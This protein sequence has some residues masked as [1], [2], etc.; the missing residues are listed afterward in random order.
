LYY[1]E[2][3]DGSATYKRQAL[4]ACKVQRLT[5]EASEEN[6]VARFSMSGIGST[7]EPNDQFGFDG[8]T[9]TA[10]DATEFPEPTDSDFPSD[11]VLFAD[12]GGGLTVATVRAFIDAVSLTVENTINARFWGDPFI[13]RATLRNRTVNLRPRV[14]FQDLATDDR[15]RLETAANFAASVV[16]AKG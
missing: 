2:L 4:R 7:P 1:A 13:K 9:A 10:P 15:T 3:P 16:F 6:P 8:Y 11:P 12:I 14:L 5:I